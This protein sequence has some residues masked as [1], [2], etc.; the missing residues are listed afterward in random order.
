M[1]YNKKKINISLLFHGVEHN[2]YKAKINQEMFININEIKKLIKFLKNKGF[3]FIFCNEYI[4][5]EKTCSI[6]FDDGYSGINEFDNFSQEYSIP[7][8]IFLN[9][10]N[11][12]NNTPF[13]WDSYKLQYKKNFDFLSDYKK[14]YESINNKTLSKLKDSKIYMPLSLEDIVKLDQNPLIK[15]SLHT[16]FHQVLMGKHFMKYNEEINKNINFFKNCTNSDIRS[17]ALPCGLYDKK[18][19]DKL[20]LNFSKIFTIDG[21]EAKNKK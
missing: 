11:I 19:I 20:S 14:G 15:F 10:Y 16:H 13:I 18:L 3:K 4:N 8:T 9:S 7:Y 12:L 21:G 5:N 17:I 6:S 1:F 2:K